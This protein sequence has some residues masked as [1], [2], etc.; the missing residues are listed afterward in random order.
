MKLAHVTVAHMLSFIDLQITKFIF[1]TVS[2]ILESNSL[3]CKLLYSDDVKAADSCRTCHRGGN[4][5]SQGRVKPFS[6][7]YPGEPRSRV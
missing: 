3:K 4:P 1:N 2:V 7:E 6:I 5:V